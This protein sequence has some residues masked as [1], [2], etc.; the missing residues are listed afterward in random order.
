MTAT[1][2][3]PSEPVPPVRAAASPEASA[4]LDARS[5]RRPG[6]FV[7]ALEGMRALA[8]LGVM[9]THVA[10]QTGAAGYPV[11]GRVLERFD[12]AV[13]VFFVLSGFLLW[14]PHAAAAR[15]LGAS[16]PAGR[17]L[18]HRAARILPAYWVV[19]CTVLILLPNA[20]HTAGLRVWLSNLALTQVFVPYTL[21]DGLTQMW[22]LSVEVA[23][24]VV[25]PLLAFAMVWLRGAR[26]RWRVP[27]VLGLAFVFLGWNFIPVPTPE[28]IHAD[29]WLPGYLPWFAM[30]M[31]LAELTD[32]EAP[33][34]RR[35]AGNRWL[36]WP[37][38]VAAMLLAATDLGGPDGLKH[39]APWQ[40]VMKTVLG[41]VIGFSLLAPLVLRP[42]IRHRWLESRTAATLGRWSYGI[43]IWHLAV[44]SIVFPV[45]GIIPFRGH[46]V[47]VYVLTLA[48]TL[49]L[50]AASFA[51]VEEP[52]R[53]WMRR[54]VG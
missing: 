23:F 26:A 33:R 2:H 6:V 53:Q 18:L 22:S 12:M 35:I 46:F 31:L 49:P 21:T 40:Y 24:Y 28:A 10:F 34:W 9:L 30:G 32:L 16:P 13:A 42:D 27:A 5:V 3:P 29:N 17:Y 8:A 14:R 7:P 41:A 38:A 52:V 15:G 11:I 1:L 48:F 50:A 43:F 25:L 51:L 47:L 54:R 45:F 44:L 19:V 20:A 36:M 39:G 37:L 4:D